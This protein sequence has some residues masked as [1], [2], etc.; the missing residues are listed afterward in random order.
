M[1]AVDDAQHKFSSLYTRR[2]EHAGR[3]HR[4]RPKRAKLLGRLFD[5]MPCRQHI[6]TAQRPDGI[7]RDRT[8]SQT[9]NEH[10]RARVLIARCQLAQ[11]LRHRA[12]RPRK[13]VG[14]PPQQITNGQRCIPSRRPAKIRIGF[15]HSDRVQRKSFQRLRPLLY[16]P[17]LRQFQSKICSHC[18]VL[19]PLPRPVCTRSGHSMRQ[20]RKIS[21]SL[22]ISLYVLSNLRGV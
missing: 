17:S 4:N 21:L 20:N 1:N 14:F 18:H 19:S 9:N 22:R 6:L 2:A 11:D 5:Q 8:V 13:C 16:A 3:Q 15:R 7:R 12:A 10:R